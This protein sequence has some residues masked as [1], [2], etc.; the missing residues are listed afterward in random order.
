MHEKGFSLAL[1]P[2]RYLLIYSVTLHSL[3]L[4]SV[5]LT[6]A[7]LLLKIPLFIM[8]SVSLVLH[9]YQTGRFGHY[10]KQPVALLNAIA[11]DW[12]IR[13]IDQSLSPVL[14]VKSAW[15]TRFAVIIHF[16]APS[17]RPCSLIVFR[18]STDYEVFRQ[19][20]VRLRLFFFRQ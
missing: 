18:D 2:S 10:P 1:R 6:N 17:A 19:L 13:Y 8:V 9:S 14:Q 3:A 20:R 15:I 12:Q 5:G 7:I 11:S 16:T 4:V